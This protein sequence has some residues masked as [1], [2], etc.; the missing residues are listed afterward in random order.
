MEERYRVVGVPVDRDRLVGS[1]GAVAAQH[2]SQPTVAVDQLG[3]L[4]AAGT[5]LEV[6]P[7]LH[8]GDAGVQ[9]WRGVQQACQVPRVRDHR[10][11]TS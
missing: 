7:G 1:G 10:F 8:L 11:V 2:P 3:D 9:R 6:Q 5:P 4:F